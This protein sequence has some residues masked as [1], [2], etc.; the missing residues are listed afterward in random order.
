MLFLKL[1]TTAFGGPAGHLGMMEDEVVRRRGWLTHEQFLDLLG[2][3]TLI[4]GPTS[5]EMA[6]HI[7]FRRAGLA[8]LLVAGVCFILPAAVMVGAIAFA[9]MRWGGRVPQAG[10]VLYGIKPVVIAV[11][12][13]AM[14]RL[15]RAA[16]KSWLLAVVGAG[17]AAANFFGAN[18][19]A[20][21][22]G[23][24]ILVVLVRAITA[25]RRGG[26]RVPMLL[27]PLPLPL[28]KTSSFALA[29][30]AGGAGLWSMSLIF[31]KIGAV[32][33][34]GGYVLVAFLRADFVNRYGWI[35]EGQLF[36]AVAV[37][38]FTPG[39]LFTT[40]TFIGYVLG[41]PWGAVAATVAIFLPGF[42][43]VAISGPFIPRLRKSPAAGAFLD[44]LNV[45]A[46]ALL[47]VVSWQLGRAA[48][49]DVRTIVICVA[50]LAVLLILRINSAWLVLA[51]AVVGLAMR[52]GGG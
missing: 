14:Y 46:L 26:A 29:S 33:F 52:A 49:F 13:Q 45:A 37:G 48:I 24:G 32:L 38:Q 1:G 35:T 12:I 17:A 51:G 11:L 6:L 34:G 8:G 22:F 40:A 23:A 5:T 30:V 44:G 2:A 41:G 7:G 39:P 3:S 16:L 31:L 43:L 21:L 15:G 18:E 36:D 20:V 4:P 9:Y 50:A 19:L 42:V 10:A 27:A 25:R 47:A 28:G